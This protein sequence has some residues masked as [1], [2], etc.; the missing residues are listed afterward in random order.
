MNRSA[1]RDSWEQYAKEHGLI[2]PAP[3][4]AATAAR[5]AAA[6]PSRNKYGAKRTQVDGIWFDSKKESA[7]YQ[8]L[9][10]MQMAGQIEALELHPKFDLHVM[11]LWHSGPIRIQTVGTF[12]ADFRYTDLKSGEIVVEDVKSEFTKNTAYKLRKRLA[13]TIHGIHVREL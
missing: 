12:S 5:E 11:E 8:E 13:E 3:V 6:L 2:K 10:L 9:K 1:L 4:G 7:R